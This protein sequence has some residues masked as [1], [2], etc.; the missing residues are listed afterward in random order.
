MNPIT[1]AVVSAVSALVAGGALGWL[2]NN[3]FG[4]RSLEATR[5]RADETLRAARREAAKDKRKAM[6]DAKEEILR[7]RRQGRPR[8][9]LPQGAAGQEIQGRQ[10]GGPRPARS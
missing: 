7:E 10:G 1:L 3:R 4:S 9:P 6:L 8:S 2:L 5:Q